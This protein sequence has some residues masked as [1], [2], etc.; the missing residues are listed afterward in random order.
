M[1][2][3]TSKHYQVY[4]G[5]VNLYYYCFWLSLCWLFFKQGIHDHCHAESPCRNPQYSP[6][7]IKITNLQ[8]MDAYEKALQHC[9]IYRYAESYCRVS[10]ICI[11]QSCVPICHILLLSLLVP[12]HILGG[13]VQPS[14][15]HMCPSASTLALRRMRCASIW[16]SRIG[17]VMSFLCPAHDLTTPIF[18][19]V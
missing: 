15:A 3:N 16:H 4:T 18:I 12:W 7:K 6:S 9:N 8:A 17:L 14:A 11:W 1:S 13:V 19:V 10:K 2:V 5:I